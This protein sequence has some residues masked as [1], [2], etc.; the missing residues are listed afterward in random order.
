MCAY[1]GSGWK[2]IKEVSC[3]RCQ[4]VK[5]C[6]AECQKSDWKTHRMECQWGMILLMADDTLVR[7]M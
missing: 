5:Y 4:E 7:A 1:D 6:T 2:R 3:H